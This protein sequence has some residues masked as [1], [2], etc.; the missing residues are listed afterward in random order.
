MPWDFS[1]QLASFGPDAAPASPSRA[2][3]YCRWVARTHYENFSV[4]SLLLP[5]RLLPHFH[6]VYAYC[7]WAD[8]LADETGDNAPGLLAWWRSSVERMYAG[9]AS[10][11][12][13]V[14]LSDT[15]RRFSI[16][17]KPLLDLLKAFEQ[18]QRV[19]RYATYDQLLAYC[20]NSANPVGVLVLHLWEC[21]DEER[22]RLSNHVCTALQEANFWQDVARDFAIGRVYIPAEDRLRF[23]VSE[24]DLALGHG[25]PAFRELMRFEVERTRTR[26]MRGYPL[27]DMVPAEV[28]PDMELFLEGGLA[29]LDAIERAGYDTLS[30]RPKLSRWAK[31]RLVLGAVWRK[32]LRLTPLGATWA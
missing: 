5:R 25:T 16:P 12:V 18:D 28:R 10:H 11:P 20:A 15:V 21:V 17:P 6:A 1:Q 7:R 22:V 9:E 29:T 26:L 32:V 23:G 19:K 8:D 24:E 13:F 3:A 14:A 30:G 31:G 2:A 27:A 4:A